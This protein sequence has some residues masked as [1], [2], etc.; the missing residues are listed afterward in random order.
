MKL[1]VAPVMYRLRRPIRTA[2]GTMDVRRGFR[3]VLEVDGV[4]GRGEAMPM[5]SFGTETEQACGAALE[6]FELGEPPDSL[7]A[8]EAATA[9]LGATPAAR[10]AVE[11]ALLEHLARRRE[12]SVAALLAFGAP[13]RTALPVNALIEGGD[14][15]S[16][17]KAAE[18]AA[19]EGFEVVKVKVAARPLATDAQRLLAVRRAV[20]PKVKI[21]IDANCGWTEGSARS[22]L[23]GL[24][25][26]DLEVCEQP[27]QP[28]DVEGLRRL[29]H[30][31][32]CRI[33]ADETMLVPGVLD[34]LLQRDPEAAADVLVL[35]P[36]AIGGLLPTLALARRGFE[37]GVEAY[38]TTLMDGP[39]GRAAAAHLAVV[40]PGRNEWAHGLSTV[41][42]LDG[43][44][45]DDFTPRRG[46][47]RFPQAMTGWGVP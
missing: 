6:A 27:V 4:A 22:A 10:F 23:R 11:C 18:A 43:V 37:A 32:P 17:A 29:R 19:L 44:G 2:Q 7:G 26:L 3:A 34:R 20:G 42:H 13:S 28:G 41:E 25:A 24:E 38:V 31:V 33:A 15:A 12:V 1:T 47:I 30:Q 8:V 35:K 45:D 14:A 36:A 9:P 40:L 5:P 39:L 16:L 21:R 46:W